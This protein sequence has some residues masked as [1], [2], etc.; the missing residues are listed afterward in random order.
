MTPDQIPF[1]PLAEM[2]AELTGYIHEH[3]REL[4]VGGM[5]FLLGLIGLIGLFRK[6]RQVRRQLAA[7]L[8]AHPTTAEDLEAEGVVRIKLALPEWAALE[9]DE[10]GRWLIVNK[11]AE[12]DERIVCVLAPPQWALS[13]TDEELA[14]WAEQLGRHHGHAG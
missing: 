9:R 14:E 13:R 1:G 12:G 8:R 11:D 2:D 4:I 10:K 3:A 6:R 5:P 7:V